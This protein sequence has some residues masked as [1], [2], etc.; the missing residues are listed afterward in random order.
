MS[1]PEGTGGSGAPAK[2]A[3]TRRNSWETRMVATRA[4]NRQYREGPTGSDERG[5][6]LV[7]ALVSIFVMGIVLLGIAQLIGVSV[8]LKKAS[9]DVTSATALA[10][11]KLEEL[12]NVDF[13][14]LVAGGSI[15]G[16]LAGFFDNPDVD[17]DGNADFTRRW[18]VLDLGAGKV[19]RVRVL[20]QLAAFGPAKESNMS[21]L[22]ARP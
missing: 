13:D 20:S 15:N 21:V 6:S 10:E 18:Q 22:I 2:G 16:D 11:Q 17:G 1:A 14:T 4:G 19:M 5:F 7:E 3:P 12:K 9:E 8:Q